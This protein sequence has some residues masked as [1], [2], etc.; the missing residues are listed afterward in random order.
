M[1]VWQGTRSTGSA[2]REARAWHPEGLVGRPGS[3][4]SGP[5]A[6]LGTKGARSKE[7]VGPAFS[8]A[9]AEVSLAKADQTS[10]SETHLPD[11]GGEPDLPF[12]ATLS[13]SR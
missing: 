11:A 4:S 8:E 6:A 12:G 5:G 13:L 9:E 7:L 1:A 10:A 3:A 2:H